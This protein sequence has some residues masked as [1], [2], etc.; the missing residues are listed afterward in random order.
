MTAHLRRSGLVVSKRQ[1]DRLMRD[2]GLTS[3][4]RGRRVR[5]TI[6]D[7]HADRAPDLLD[8]DFTAEAPNRRWSTDFTYVTTWA[9]FAYV[10]FMIDCCSRDR[11][12]AR[13]NREDDPAGNTA[14]RMGLWRRDLAGHP[15][16]DG[17]IHH[18]DAGSQSTRVSFAR[19]SRRKAS[20]R[21][22]DRSATRM[23]VR[24]SS[25]SW[26]PDSC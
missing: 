15:A 23:T 26:R 18:S 1:V 21:P 9:G 25:A 5:T 3:L 17:L 13:R 22:S 19:R 7:R 10:S 12:L 14:L 16:V 24:V 20:P 4:V 8:R 11:G 6:P 2:L